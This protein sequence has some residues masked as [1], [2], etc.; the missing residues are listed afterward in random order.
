MDV[1]VYPGGESHQHNVLISVNYECVP[2]GVPF[3]VHPGSVV[4]WMDEQVGFMGEQVG[5][6]PW[7]L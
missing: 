6:S 1:F 4:N 3:E 7:S 2:V 5:R